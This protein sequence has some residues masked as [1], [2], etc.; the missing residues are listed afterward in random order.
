MPSRLSNKIRQQK[1]YLARR[2][3]SQAYVICT[4]VRSTFTAL[5]NLDCTDLMTFL[6]LYLINNYSTSSYVSPR[7]LSWLLPLVSAQASRSNKPIIVHQPRGGRRIGGGSWKTSVE[8]SSSK[9][10]AAVTSSH[11]QRTR[12]SDSFS[13]LSEDAVPGG[14]YVIFDSVPGRSLKSVP[15]CTSAA[16]AVF[17]PLRPS[18]SP[19]S[20]P[21][22]SSSSEHFSTLTPPFQPSQPTWVESQSCHP[23]PSETYLHHPPSSQANHHYSHGPPL[24]YNYPAHSHHHQP[25]HPPYE[26]P[27]GPHDT[28]RPWHLLPTRTSLATP[29]AQPPSVLSVSPASRFQFNVE[30]PVNSSCYSGSDA[31]FTSQDRPSSI[32]T[33]PRSCHERPHEATSS[34]LSVHKRASSST[35]QRTDVKISR[36]KAADSQRPSRVSSSEQSKTSED[37]DD[38]QA[39]ETPT[40]SN[41]VI[42]CPTVAKVKTKVQVSNN[43]KCHSPVRPPDHTPRPPNSW[44]LYWSD[45]MTQI[46]TAKAE[47]REFEIPPGL[48]KGVEREGGATL[49]KDL[50]KLISSFWRNESKEVKTAYEQLSLVKKREVSPYSLRR[51]CQRGFSCSCSSVHG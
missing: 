31:P 3:T 19:Q 29:F 51:R 41:T 33:R 24:P 8:K 49:Q 20:S 21:T 12:S 34:H 50:S 48:V 1:R 25:H 27:S 5:R 18:K 4:H 46:K 39:D 9:R 22:R 47:G 45:V 16:Q 15:A 13:N 10:A 32:G 2:R 23:P 28:F 30:R 36:L 7:S 37:D 44:I 42:V 38:L 40:T 26:H 11:A 43:V 14:M 35:L 17:E 6:G